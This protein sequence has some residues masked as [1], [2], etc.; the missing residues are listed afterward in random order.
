EGRE[1]IVHITRHSL[2]E[3]ISLRVVSRRL[4]LLDLKAV[5]QRFNSVDGVLGF[6]PLRVRKGVGS[7]PTLVNVGSPKLSNSKLLSER[8]AHNLRRLTTAEATSQIA[9]A[10]DSC[11]AHTQQ[12]SQQAEQHVEETLFSDKKP[13]AVIEG[14]FKEAFYRNR[15]W[16]LSLTRRMLCA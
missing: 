3:S 14:W 7:N 13:A 9:D 4:D 12:A 10:V 11:P 5:A 1:R 2:R 6:Y 8:S 15:T 16:D